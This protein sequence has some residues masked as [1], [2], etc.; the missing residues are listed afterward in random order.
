M[1]SQHVTSFNL[2][3]LLSIDIM[4]QYI[5]RIK[6]IDAQILKIKRILNNGD[7]A[8][9]G[10]ELTFSV[11]P[12][13]QYEDVDNRPRTHDNV[14][15]GIS[16]GA[17]SDQTPLLNL[18]CEGLLASRKFNHAQLTREVETARLFLETTPI[19]SNLPRL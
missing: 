8:A 14:V 10:I 11:G 13:S 7:Y 1:D 2:N 9:A 3:Q 6:E 18:I 12:R 5:D 15:E 16:L 19:P 17:M 4:K